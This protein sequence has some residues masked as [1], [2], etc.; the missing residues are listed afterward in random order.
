MF[1]SPPTFPRCRNTARIRGSVRN[2]SVRIA[3][4]LSACLDGLRSPTSV[5]VSRSHCGRDC[6]CRR[7]RVSRLCKRPPREHHHLRHLQGRHHS[8]YSPHRPLDRHRAHQQQRQ[9]FPGC[10]SART[11]QIQLVVRGA[12]KSRF[13]HSDIQPSYPRPPG[14]PVPISVSTA[15]LVA[16]ESASRLRAT[17]AMPRPSPSPSSWVRPST[18]PSSRL[19]PPL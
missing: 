6:V 19:W 18:T 1:S 10:S 8:R 11:S 4:E 9:L 2:R 17:S 12:G 13:L 7:L 15:S 3:L 5:C 14:S 16:P